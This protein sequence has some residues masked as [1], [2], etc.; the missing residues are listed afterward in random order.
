M[1]GNVDAH[2][3]TMSIGVVVEQ[4]C[5]PNTQN[6][7]DTTQ[8]LARVEGNDNFSVYRMIIIATG[9]SLVICIGL[10][11]QQTRENLKYMQKL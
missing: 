2:A 6:G 10:N 11:G 9:D 1:S 7:E 8:P 5:W 4:G 3:I